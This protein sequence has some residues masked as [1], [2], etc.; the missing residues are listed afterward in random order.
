MKRNQ[1]L[2]ITVLIA[3]IFTFLFYKNNIGI[4]LLIFEWIMIPLMIYLNKPIKLN[5]LSLTILIS[6]IISSIMV[7]VIHTPWTIFINLALLLN[8]SGTI[9][10]KEFRSFANSSIDSFIRI[11][12]THFSNQNFIDQTKHRSKTST[13][14]LK[15]FLFGIVPLFFLLTFFLIYIGASSKFASS[16]KPLFNFLQ[17]LYQEINIALVFIFIFGIIVSN[18]LL[19]KSKSIG[20]LNIDKNSSNLLKR[21]RKYHYITFKKT[22]LRD[23]NLMGIITLSVLNILILI[24]N[25]TD[26]KSVWFFNWDGSFLREF[27]HEGTWLLIFSIFLSALI[28]LFFFKDNL[29]FYS[30]NKWLKR[31]TIAWI[32]Q[33]ILMTISVIIRNYWYITYFGL[34]YKRIA[35]LFFLLL[36]IYG[37]TTIIIK[38]IH[39]KSSYYLL[40]VNSFATLIILTLSSFVDWNVV[41]AKYNFSHAHQSFIEY[42]FMASILEPSSLP[43]TIKTEEELKKIDSLQT[44]T[45]PFNIRQDYFWD[46]NRYYDEVMTR[47]ENFIKNYQNQKPLEW[48]LS[49]YR[50][51]KRLIK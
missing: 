44:K 35:V 6:L 1:F 4:N 5:P 15:I 16:M 50:T 18:I 9:V 12:T 25:I 45:M 49:D 39:K 41:I 51:Y 20:L 30:K 48:N 26:I 42:R 31:L 14:L 40:R 11:F 46:S 27:V 19:R 47:K 34:A 38:I 22:G 21:K 28:A 13:I 7:I 3:V 24:F 23:Q 32:V 37:L 2:I 29:N 43:Y 36:A 8:A 33:N 10:F 17:N